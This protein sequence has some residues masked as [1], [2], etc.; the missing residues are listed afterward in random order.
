MLETKR[1]FGSLDIGSSANEPVCVTKNGGFNT[2]LLI[3]WEGSSQN[4]LKLIVDN[5]T[6]T[7]AC[8][9]LQSTKCFYSFHS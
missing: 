7:E 4:R 5:L 3:R 9:A 1:T 8:H 6:K 2:L